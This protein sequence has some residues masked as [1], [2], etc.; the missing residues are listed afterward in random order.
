MSILNCQ[1]FLFGCRINIGGLVGSGG[2]GRAD[3]EDLELELE[4]PF[5]LAESTKSSAVRID[6]IPVSKS[7]GI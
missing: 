1:F 4:K 6:F 5:V 2:G 7:G 3:S